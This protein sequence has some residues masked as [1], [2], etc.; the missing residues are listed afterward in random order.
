MRKINLYLIV[1]VFV[2]LKKIHVDD[3]FI[4]NKKEYILFMQK[5]KTN[6]YIQVIIRNNL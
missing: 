1:N 3:I 4:Q 6:M 2:V 5:T